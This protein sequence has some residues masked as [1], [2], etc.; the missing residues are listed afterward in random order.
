MKPC[1]EPGD[2][3]HPWIYHPACIAVDLGLPDE[4]V[5]P[6]IESMMT[7]DPIGN[8]IEEAL[9]SAWGERR[10]SSP[11]WP[12]V[13]EEQVEAITLNGPRLIE[14][15]KSSPQKMAI[16][17]ANRAELIIDSLFS[18]DSL[19]CVGFSQ[20]T[21]CTV[22]RKQLAGSLENFAL[23]VPSPMTAEQGWTKDGRLSQHTLTNT[24]ERRF[25]VIEFDKGTLDQQAALLFHLSK[26]APSLALAVFSGSKSLHGW[27]YCGNQAED[28]QLRLMRY[29]VSLG[30]DRA[31][32]TRS[33][34]VRMPDG[35]R[36]R[37]SGSTV[38]LEAC[39]F[40]GV[41]AR[42][43]VALYFNPDVVK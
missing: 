24:A 3:V 34:F 43:Q 10:R 13:N 41:P 39:G 7:R 36:E 31:T 11:A 29:S 37:F 19:L 4:I 14:L 1:P 5:I 30:A 6:E 40:S 21:F 9:A 2:G 33:Q 26:F 22:S 20:K 27:F 32:W 35:T 28:A 16:T 8:E 17:N 15:W 38:A 18:A 42:K 23:I 25:L 12:K